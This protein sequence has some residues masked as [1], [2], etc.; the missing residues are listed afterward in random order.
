MRLTI[1]AGIGF[2][3]HFE[4]GTVPAAA[5][6]AANMELFT[7]LGLEVAVTELD[8]RMQLPETQAQLDQQKSDFMNVVQACMV[9]SRLFWRS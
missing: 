2:E 9:R 3:S 1:K 7:S 6:I 4:V 5:D 8:V